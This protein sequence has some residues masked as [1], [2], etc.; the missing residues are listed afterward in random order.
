VELEAR[1]RGVEKIFITV[2]VAKDKKVNIRTFYLTEEVD[3]WWKTNKDRLLWSYFPRS[4]FLEELKMSGSM[5][6][7]QYAS[8]FTEL[9]RFVPEFML[10]ERLKM[11]RFEEG[12]GFYIRK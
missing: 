3:F 6:V 12:L 7:M 5:T 1:I 10:P 2:E 11:R 8:K 4:R 9:S